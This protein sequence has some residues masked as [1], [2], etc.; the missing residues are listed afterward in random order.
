MLIRPTDSV[1]GTREYGTPTANREEILPLLTLCEEGRLY[2][3]EKWIAEGRPI[4][5]VPPCRTEKP[6]A[7]QTPLGIVTKKGFHS[8]AELLLINGYD[9]NGDYYEHILPAV[10]AKNHSM[11]DLLLRYGADPAAVEFADVLDTY[12]RKLMDC[13]VAAGADPCRNNAVACAMRRKARPLLGFVKTYR[14]QFPGIQRQIDIA[15]HHFVDEKDEKGVALMLWLK[16]NPYAEVPSDPWSDE[17]R[18]QHEDDDLD[19]AL[20]TAMWRS[21]DAIIQRLLKVPIPS[22]S[23]Q[24]LL[25]SVSS[26]ACPAVVKKVLAAGANPNDYRGGRHIL[27]SFLRALSSRWFSTQQAEKDKR[28]LEALRLIAEAGAKW[29]LDSTGLTDLRRSMLN[30]ESKTIVAALDI[31]RS[32]GVLNA[33]QLQELTRTSGMKRLLAGFSKPKKH[34]FGSIARPVYPVVLS[35]PDPRRGYWKR[36]WS[37]RM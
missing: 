37:Q 23:V 36:H 9:P 16:A 19:C 13:F 32:F 25:R 12:D 2:E 24:P 28:G 31:L 29:D 33:D 7:R 1:T 22:E 10:E 5:A 14:D 17:A 15:L 3:V 18:D 6:S 4:Q 26:C 30:G 8:L 20:V 21:N 27:D 11:V 35:E 34:L